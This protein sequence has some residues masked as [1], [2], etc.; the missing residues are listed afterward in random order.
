MN[1][2]VTTSSTSYLVQERY[3][4]DSNL[5]VGEQMSGLF[6]MSHS[7]ELHSGLYILNGADSMSIPR[8][9]LTTKPLKKG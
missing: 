9:I 3:I 6:T 7:A 2:K 8:V 4:Y 1:L 5:M